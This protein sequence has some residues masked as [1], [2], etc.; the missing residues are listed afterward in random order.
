MKVEKISKSLNKNQKFESE[1]LES[2]KTQKFE[3]E[4]LESNKTRRSLLP[5][6]MMTVPSHLEEVRRRRSLLHRD[7]VLRTL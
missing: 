4:P 6:L 7:L 5:I 3:S 2:N 1:L